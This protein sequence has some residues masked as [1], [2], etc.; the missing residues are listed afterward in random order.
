MT[1]VTL[2]ASCEPW[3]SVLGAAVVGES[4]ATGAVTSA[5]PALLLSGAF[6]PV[7]PAANAEHAGATLEQSTAVVQAGR[8]HGIWYGDDC[9]ASI[10]TAF[11]AAP[12]AP[13]DTAC[14]AA[15][16]PVEWAAP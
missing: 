9:I 12:S 6:D 3:I 10:V 8:G 15:G 13:P 11:V 14:A 5:V 7:T 16:V 2:A 4:R 1:A